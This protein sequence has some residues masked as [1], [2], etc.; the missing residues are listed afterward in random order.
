MFNFSFFPFHLLSLPQCAPFPPSK[1]LVKDIK[2]EAHWR[3]PM[4]NDESED[5]RERIRDIYVS[6]T[7]TKRSSDQF[8][9]Q[10]RR[11][12]MSQVVRDF[13]RDQPEHGFKV[14]HILDKVTQNYVPVA[15]RGNL[16]LTGYD[17]ILEWAHLDGFYED[18]IVGTVRGQEWLKKFGISDS[19]YSIFT[20]DEQNQRK[21]RKLN[22]DNPS[23]LSAEDSSQSNANIGM[24]Q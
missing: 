23:A 20:E 12:K 15:S 14:T 16:T 4:G 3:S 11:G 21:R 24:G 7:R 13:L 2:D 19:P 5:D 9:S 1:E 18:Q 22:P 8:G 17:D 6:S 10:Q